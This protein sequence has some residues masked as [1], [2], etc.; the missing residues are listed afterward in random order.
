MEEDTE[1]IDG[2]KYKVIRSTESISPGAYI[3]VG[4]PEGIVDSFWTSRGLP[5][6]E[7]FATNLHNILFERGLFTFRDIAA[8]GVAAGVIQEAV[9]MD[10]Q[11]LVDMFKQFEMEPA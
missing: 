11:I 10:A 4:P 9:Q 1:T 3:T 2:R 6:P 5:V 8:R 7:P